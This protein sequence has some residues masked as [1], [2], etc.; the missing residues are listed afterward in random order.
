V[1]TALWLSRSKGRRGHRV[2]PRSGWACALG[3]A[4]LLL[5]VSAQAGHLGELSLHNLALAVLAAGQHHRGHAVPEALVHAL[6]RAHRQCRAVAGRAGRDA[7][8][9]RCWSPSPWNCT[10]SCV[11]AMAWSVL[12]LTLGGSSL[13]YLLIQRGAATQVTSLMYL[14]PPCTA[15]LAWLLFGELARPSRSR[16]PRC[17]SSVRARRSRTRSDPALR[18]GA[19]RS[20]HALLARTTGC[21]AQPVERRPYKA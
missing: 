7:C 4:G 14:V 10:R 6:R 16:P 11:G 8:R 20:G 5:V 9:W 13:L 19:G 17:R 3:L 12:V 21:L 18:A 2:T 15:L 1:L